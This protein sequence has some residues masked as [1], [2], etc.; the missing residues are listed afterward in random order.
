ML[1]KVFQGNGNY[2]W[3]GECIAVAPG[4]SDRVLV[5]TRYD[6]MWKTDDGGQNWYQVSGIPTDANGAGV[7]SVGFHPNNSSVAYATVVG[8]GIYGSTDGGSNWS[9]LSGSPANPA[10]L[11][12]AGDGI[13][14]L[15]ADEG[16]F[17]YDGAFTEVS[18]SAEA[19]NALAVDPDNSDHVVVSQTGG[20]FEL[21]VYRT[22]DGGSAW[23]NVNNYS[24]FTN[25]V[26]WYPG[27]WKMAA[28]SCLIMRPGNPNEVWFGDWFQAWM[29]D[30]L[31]A[32]T[33][34]WESQPWGH[35]E[36]CVFDLATPCAPSEVHLLNGCADNGGLRHTDVTEYPTVKFGNQESTGLDFCEAYPDELVRVSSLGWGDS[37]F[38]IDV[39]S[40]GGLNWQDVYYPGTTGK[41]QMSSSNPDNI[42]YAPTGENVSL[43]YSQD[44]GYNWYSAS[45][46]PTATFNS[47]FWDNYNKPIASDRRNGGVFY[48]FIPGTLYA[49][50]DGGAN[51]SARASGLPSG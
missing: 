39:S 45:G 1:T 34:H 25:N 18:P 50:E 4:D 9:Y 41:L 33:V 19:F 48:C 24:T 51:W 40:D 10:R 43:L 11:Q 47:W 32:A 27:N 16:V 6:G 2:R 5:G 49:S 28:T 35:E 3:L 37:N 12:V 42:I 31:G 36:L 44:G 21:P 14:Y 7:R 13:L 38:K 26:P 46:L 20:S 17:R 30:D 29:G 23:D 22:L 8:S 15:T